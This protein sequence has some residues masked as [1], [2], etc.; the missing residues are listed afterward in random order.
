MTILGITLSAA[1]IWLIAAAVFGV[2]EA[3]TLGL[4]TIW[5]AGGAI[6]A[7]IAAMAGASLPVQAVVFLAL[8]ILLLYFTRPLAKKKLKVGSEKTN[9]DALV[10]K[11]AL[12]TVAIPPMGTGQAKV[13]GLIWTAAAK[14]SRQPIEAGTTVTI[15]RIE[16][17]KLIVTPSDL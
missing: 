8:S 9:V 7:S 1:V 13:D 11:K 14:E 10:G 16:G 15:D 17:V 5:F 2:I 12:I 6:A 4:T 3:L